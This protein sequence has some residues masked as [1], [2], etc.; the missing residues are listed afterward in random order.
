MKVCKIIASCCPKETCRSSFRSQYLDLRAD[1]SIGI[2]PAKDP[3]QLLRSCY[4]IKPIR[5]AQ[6][7]NSIKLSLTK[8]G[9]FGWKYCRLRVLQKRRSES[10]R[11]AL[12]SFAEGHIRTCVQVSEQRCGGW[13]QFDWNFYCFLGA[14]TFTAASSEN[15]GSL[16]GLAFY[17]LQE[18]VSK[19]A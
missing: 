7:L 8:D 2:F 10:I 1:C 15:N 18:P 11:F 14:K 6:I 13:R 12:S 19:Y 3:G 4:F 16:T 17:G 9:L 5:T